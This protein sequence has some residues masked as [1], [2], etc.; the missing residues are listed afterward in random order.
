MNVRRKWRPL[1]FGRNK[2]GD[3]RSEKSGY[4]S[5]EIIRRAAGGL[6]LLLG[7]VFVPSLMNNKVLFRYTLVIAHDFIIICYCMH[8]ILCIMVGNDA[9]ASHL[10]VHR[11]CINLLWIHP[12]GCAP[13]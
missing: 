1:F 4:F 10:G 2:F 3:E 11:E 8:I 6:L 7:M 13:L 12:Q 5:D 9:P